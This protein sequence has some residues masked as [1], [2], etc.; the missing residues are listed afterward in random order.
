MGGDDGTQCLDDEDG[1][2]LVTESSDDGLAF[3]GQPKLVGPVLLFLECGLE[4]AD[5][6]LENAACYGWC[7]AGLF[8]VCRG[9][10]GSRPCPG[11][12]PA[13]AHVQTLDPGP[14]LLGAGAAPP[15]AF[16]QPRCDTKDQRRGE[17]GRSDDPRRRRVTPWNKQRDHQSDDADCHQKS[18]YRHDGH[19]RATATLPLH[20][21]CTGR[22]V[23]ITTA[24]DNAP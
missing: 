21:G 13:G 17:C 8:L 15:G 6:Q 20:T 12:E 7:S 3:G 18:L 14:S 4:A 2:L 5:L 11:L 9:R 10:A 23:E 16:E 19:D 24:N 22:L 1:S